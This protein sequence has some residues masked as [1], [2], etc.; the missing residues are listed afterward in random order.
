L[1]KKITDAEKNTD[2]LKRQLRQAD[3]KNKE[4]Q[5]KLNE[6]AEQSRQSE[7]T[8]ESIRKA[9]KESQAAIIAHHNELK[10]LNTS[11]KDFKKSKATKTKT[12]KAERNQLEICIKKKTELQKTLDID[13]ERHCA[14]IRAVK[15]ERETAKQDLTNA[16]SIIEKH[17]LT[18][19]S[20]L[21][22]DASMTNK[23]RVALDDVKTTK[24]ELSD[25]TAKH[26]DQQAKT[27]AVH[28]RAITA[29]KKKVQIKSGKARLEQI[30]KEKNDLE[31]TPV[32][33]QTQHSKAES[34]IQELTVE[35]THGS[36]EIRNLRSHAQLVVAAFRMLERDADLILGF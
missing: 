32:V 19:E 11:L 17:K 9:L 25:A 21:K 5:T 30:N 4:V 1:A 20:W 12:L 22:F 31:K 36:E 16:Q 28:Q 15:S 27:L 13:K 7:E 26:D 33:E 23:C 14:D 3:K 10:I 29:A 34:D 35:L 24:K 2:T 6:A 8:L 18:M